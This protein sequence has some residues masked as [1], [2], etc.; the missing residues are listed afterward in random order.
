MNVAMLRLQ[1]SAGNVANAFTEG[2]L[3]GAAN[4]SGYPGAYVPLRVNQVDTAGGG[5]GA[6][7]GTVTPSYIATYDPGAPFADDKGMVAS[8]NVDLTSEAIE[9]IM[10][11]YSFAAN[12]AVVR[13]DAQVTATLLD[14]VV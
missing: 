9:Q 12:A 6:T 7:V 1:V 5:T 13:V 11:R 10:A 14:T 8:P 2:P 4:A 3:P